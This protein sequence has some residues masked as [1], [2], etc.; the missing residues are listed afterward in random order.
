MTEGMTYFSAF[1]E[2]VNFGAILNCFQYRW[3]A[4]CIANP[5]YEPEDM[6]KAILHALSSSEH[7]NASFLAVMVLPV[8]DDSPWTSNAIRGHT[9]MSTIIR[10]T[11]GHV[12]F[13]PLTDKRTRLPWSSNRPNGQ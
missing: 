4:S 6:L 9:N 8:W 13:C 1:P 5:E 7:T 3:I 10:I 12:G 11:S 2:D